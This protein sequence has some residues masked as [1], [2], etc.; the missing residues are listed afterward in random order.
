M[1]A[2]NPQPEPEADW[3]VIVPG[4]PWGGKTAAFG[5][6]PEDGAR[7]MFARFAAPFLSECPPK[8]LRVIEDYARTGPAEGQ[9]QWRLMPGTGDE[10]AE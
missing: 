1:N 5:P 8:L 4:A 2:E 3:Y 9:F 10:A 7:E 6:M